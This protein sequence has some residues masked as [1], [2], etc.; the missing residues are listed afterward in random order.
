MSMKVSTMHSIVP[1][2]VG[3]LPLKSARHTAFLHN[4]VPGIE[5]PD[6]IERGYLLQKMVLRL[7]L[8]LHTNSFSKFGKLEM[9]GVFI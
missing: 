3:V 4:E 5:I 1:L 2:I 6:S 7:V 8:Q 9:C